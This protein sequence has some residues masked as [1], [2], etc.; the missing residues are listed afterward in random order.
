MVLSIY[1]N[2]YEYTYNIDIH[3]HKAILSLPF[4]PGEV[5]INQKGAC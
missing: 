4:L 3:S 1:T 2:I 5:I